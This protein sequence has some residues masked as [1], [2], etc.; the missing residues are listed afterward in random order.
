M[1]TF[2]DLSPSPTP[3]I[4]Y[5]ILVVK[6]PSTYAV[7]LYVRSR[8]KCDYCH[9]KRECL[10]REGTDEQYIH[11]SPVLT[12]IRHSNSVW[13]RAPSCPQQRDR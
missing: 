7:L 11:A 4:F 3:S 8:K 5:I 12:F 1:G 2:P 6:L 13:W 9:T 10:R